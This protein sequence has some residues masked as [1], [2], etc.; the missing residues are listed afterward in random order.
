MWTF[1]GSRWQWDLILCDKTAIWI[2]TMVP[3]LVGLNFCTH[4]FCHPFSTLSKCVYKRSSWFYISYCRLEEHHHYQHITLS[5]VIENIWISPACFSPIPMHICQSF[6][7]PSRNYNQTCYRN[8]F[9]I[10]TDW[11]ELGLQRETHGLREKTRLFRFELHESGD[12]TAV[13]SGIEKVLY[14]CSSIKHIK[15][16]LH[17][18]E[19]RTFFPS[20]CIVFSATNNQP[21]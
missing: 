8:R 20:L 2:C 9:P 10:L 15:S 17:C 6:F 19:L 5:N 21:D 4:Y 7:W 13:Y 3:M 16:S 1:G 14:L 18:C 11:L 12:F